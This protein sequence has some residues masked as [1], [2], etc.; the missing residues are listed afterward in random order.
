[1]PLYKEIIP[2]TYD[3]EL[4]AIVKLG[5][6]NLGLTG[7]IVGEKLNIETSIQ[8]GVEK[9][10]SIKLIKPS[11]FRVKPKCEI[12]DRCGGCNLQHINYQHQLSIKTSIIQQL[13]KNVLKSTITVSPILGMNYPYN[14]RNKSQVAFKYQ[15]GKN[16]CGFYIEGT[17]DVVDFDN[18]YLQNEESNKIF[19]TI[20][21]LMQKM[22][23][24]TYDE[25][26][27]TGIIRHILIKSAYPTNDLL[28][29]IVTGSS[30][31][32]GKA[33][34]I[35]A[36]V[37]RH[38]KIK[39]I[40][41]NVN[42]RKTSAVLGTN[43]SVIYGKGFIIDELLG[44]KFKITSK[45][46]YQIN[47]EQTE[48]LYSLVIDA[49]NISSND[50]V[51]DAYCG[52]GT[53]GLLASRYAKKVIGVE[54]VKD[55]VLNANFNAKLNNVKN[56]SFFSQDATDFI[57]NMVRRKE[58]IDILI[59]DPPRSGSTKEFLYAAKQLQPKKIIYVSCNPYTLVEDLKNIIDDYDIKTIMPVDMFPH[60]HHVETVICL[61]KK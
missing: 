36:L 52:V 58:K 51:L 4:K 20:K 5:K 41:Q 14:Y 12:F 26:K 15:N 54:L 50:V 19:K 59:M 13:F 17:H 24:S 40:I 1:M 35:K 43:E 44:Y 48:K 33:N 8:N 30:N 3:Q 38:P 34:F 42:D 21:D 16:K 55:A 25:D 18:C 37:A 56:I 45:S 53:I 47:H 2:S 29:V 22:R 46:F 6:N 31:F 28:V 49:S 23:I 32:P 61:S 7:F 11:E 60:T 39:T 57:S 10:K 9:V 27:K